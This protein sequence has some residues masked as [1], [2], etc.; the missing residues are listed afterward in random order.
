M[1]WEEG[2]IITVRVLG[3]K[4]SI[5]TNDKQI[6]EERTIWFGNLIK[7]G[8]R[9]VIYP[10]SLQVLSPNALHTLS[11]SIP[12]SS[13]L[14]PLQ[15]DCPN[16][17]WGGVHLPFISESKRSKPMSSWFYTGTVFTSIEGNEHNFVKEHKYCRFGLSD[18]R[19]AWCVKI[20]RCMCASDKCASLAFGECL[21]GSYT[22]Q[23]Y[24]DGSRPRYQAPR[25]STPSID[26]WWWSWN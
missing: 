16:Q 9:N 24:K 4:E 21:N 20:G 12:T 10:S 25:K 8:L 7:S 18:A 11:G 1:V 3:Y 23:L 6:A 19:C 13:P 17:W 22:P 2:S 5:G 15:C 14:L 26:F